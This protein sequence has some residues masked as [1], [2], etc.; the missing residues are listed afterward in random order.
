[1][2]RGQLEVE[3]M[4]ISHLQQAG[5]G[6]LVSG[7][8]IEEEEQEVVKKAAGRLMVKVEEVLVKGAMYL[9]MHGKVKIKLV[10]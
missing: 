3:A 1:M 4:I 8:D 6:D 7:T 5:L 9:V 10:V 2:E